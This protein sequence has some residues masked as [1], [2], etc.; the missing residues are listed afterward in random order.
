MG[1]YEVY[2]LCGQYGR[3]MVHTLAGVAGEAGTWFIQTPWYYGHD[4]CVALT[5]N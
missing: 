3:C 5:P 1:M 2:G 4:C